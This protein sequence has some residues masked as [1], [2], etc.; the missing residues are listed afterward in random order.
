CRRGP[1]AVRGCEPALEEQLSRVDLEL[2]LLHG[3]PDPVG[4]VRA[5]LGVLVEVED[6]VRPH[7]V[8]LA[9]EHHHHAR[10][11]AAHQVLRDDDADF[12]GIELD[13]AAYRER[14]DALDEL[15]DE[16]GVIAGA[17]LLVQEAERAR[18]R[19]RLGVRPHR[20]QRV[21]GIGDRRDRAVEPD[22]LAFEPA[23]V[24]AAVFSRRLQTS[25]SASGL[26]TTLSVRRVTDSLTSLPSRTVL[27][28]VSGRRSSFTAATVCV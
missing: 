6:L 20:G 19:Q 17:A 9:V 22:L 27:P 10:L 21:E 8:A 13:H 12:G 23:R 14:A 3:A 1:R 25:T 4:L 2:A 11:E 26:R 24:T 5:N 15:L 16:L 28:W 7:R 18:W